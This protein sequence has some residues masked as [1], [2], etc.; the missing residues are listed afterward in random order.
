[1][2]EPDFAQTRKKKRRLKPLT[3]EGNPSTQLEDSKSASASK[4]KKK[5]TR[6]RDAHEVSHIADEAPE[7]SAGTSYREDGTVV[8]EDRVDDTDKMQKVRKK[9]RQNSILAPDD[10]VGEK[11][12][13]EERLEKTEPQLRRQLPPAPGTTAEIQA[14]E[15]DHVQLGRSASSRK[16]RKQPKKLSRR[17]SAV[18][19]ETTEMDDMFAGEYEISSEDII[20]GDVRKASAIQPTRSLP[21]SQPIGKVFVEKKDGKG[22][23]TQSRQALTETNDDLQPDEEL[24]IVD[25]TTSEFAL[26]VVS[27]FRW[28][29]FLCH[30]LAAGFGLWQCVGVYQLDAAASSDGDFLGL[31][32]N[33]SQVT[34]SLYYFLFAVCCVSVLE[35]YESVHAHSTSSFFRKFQL[36][37]S[38]C[39]AVV[40]Y[41]VGL[42]VTLAVA[43]T[44]Y[45]IK[46]YDERP[47]L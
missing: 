38:Y 26:Q 11:R 27:L 9:K 29:A 2:S 42:V 12:R 18:G 10:E 23:V 21:T 32:E 16:P 47:D 14:G 19:P 34:Q 4:E 7:E 43:N 13:A 22:F 44:D 31:Y 40:I 3:V 28:F 46:L 36:R 41:V 30:G 24:I 15:R 17:Q 8:F 20:A 1:M 25:K 35:S 5:K 39:L 37:P 6:S 33:T 45:R